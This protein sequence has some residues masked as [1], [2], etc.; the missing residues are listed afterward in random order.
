[1]EAKS[2]CAEV[3]KIGPTSREKKKVGHGAAVGEWKD[4]Y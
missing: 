3:R 4:G 1:M 2:E